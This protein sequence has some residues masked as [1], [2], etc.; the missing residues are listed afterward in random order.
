METVTEDTEIAVIP[1]RPRQRVAAALVDILIAAIVLALLI[2]LFSRGGADEVT[3]SAATT[4]S[5]NG[6]TG[7]VFAI[8][9]TLL[10]I[11]LVFVLMA[12][13]RLVTDLLFRTSPG[14][15][16]VDLT[17]I[18]DDKN[19]PPGRLRLLLRDAGNL[20]AAIVP[21][22]NVIWAITVLTSSEGSGRVDS[23]TGTRVTRRPAPEPFVNKS[24]F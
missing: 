1:A 19:V 10:I 7:V 21:V 18:S 6:D 5:E 17:V 8:F 23:I 12:A 13:F 2:A 4:A 24:F 3:S 9:A 15:W 20:V 14:R 16:L 11:D 22:A